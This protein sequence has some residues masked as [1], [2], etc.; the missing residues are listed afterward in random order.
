MVTA[1]MPEFMTRNEELICREL[2]II[3][4]KRAEA[5]EF[6]QS[7][8]LPA[9]WSSL[10]DEKIWVILDQRQRKRVRVSH[11]VGNLY[12][13]EFQYALRPKMSVEKN[14][15]RVS[16]IKDKRVLNEKPF[17]AK[18]SSREEMMEEATKLHIK[19]AEWLDKNYPDWRKVTAYWD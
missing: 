14:T 6:L 2:G 5:K 18:F 19:A 17:E 3:F 12:H 7:V 4:G 9:G 11:Q 15:V 10:G 16:V 1:V 13:V 8:D